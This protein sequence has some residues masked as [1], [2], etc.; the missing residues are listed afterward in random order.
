METAAAAALKAVE[1]F[2]QQRF[3]CRLIDIDRIQVVGSELIVL[4][5]QVKYEDRELQIFGSCRATDNL[6]NTSARAAL[7]AT[8]RFVELAMEEKDL[9]NGSA[10]DTAYPHDQPQD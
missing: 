6:L 8:N 9:I 10:T 1:S 2:V 3:E 7:D 4:L 5:V